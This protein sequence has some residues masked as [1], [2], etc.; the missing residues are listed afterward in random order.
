[1]NQRPLISV[2]IPV[3]N[4]AENLPALLDELEAA[5]KDM[6]YEAVFVDD[7]SRDQS[8]A[9]LKER[10][11]R[12]RRIKIVQFN[13]NFGQQAA[14]MAGYQSAR[15]EIIVTMDADRQNDPANI[16]QFVEKI[17]KEGNAAAF[18]WRVNRENGFFT[19]QLPSRMF[20]A[21]R[22]RLLQ[23]PLHDY[24]CALNAFRREFVDE[25]ADSP[26]YLKH[27]T[28]YIA[29]KRVP[30]VEVQIQERKRL[31]G[32]SHY[33]FMRLLQLGLDLV[34]HTTQKPV[35]TAALLIMA[36]FSAML[37]AAS[38]VYA[39]VRIASDGLAGAVWLLVPFLFAFCALT[40][41]AL[42]LIN[43]KVSAL[44]RHSHKKPLYIIKEHLD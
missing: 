8:F 14:F 28:T 2:V 33:N 4:E 44:L 36:A 26:G 39:A 22:N 32:R 42:A 18:G 31:A 7:G 10:R 13:D 38:G 9:I 12:N 11:E 6:D 29:A 35:I 23:R 37:F 40:C 30:Y 34:V 41:G 21:L 27:I 25:L 1:M 43:E 5:L 17:T 16:P 19:R 15:G 24:G 3:Y 20:N